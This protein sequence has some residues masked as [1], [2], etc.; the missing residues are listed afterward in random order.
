MPHLQPLGEGSWSMNESGQGAPTDLARRARS[1]MYRRR[2]IGVALAGAVVAGGVF[3]AVRSSTGRTAAVTTTTVITEAPTTTTTPPSTVV[4]TEPAST[5]TAVT[6]SAAPDAAAYR[7]ITRRDRDLE[8]TTIGRNGASTTKVVAKLLDVLGATPVL[9]GTKD[10]LLVTYLGQVTVYDPATWA[11][12]VDAGTYANFGLVVTG[13]GFWAATDN[14]ATWQLRDWSG[15]P[16]GSTVATKAQVTLPIGPAG[17]GVALLVK[18]TFEILI[19]EPGGVR[20]SG[21]G[22]PIAANGT[23]LAYQAES[24]DINIVNVQTAAVSVISKP[25]DIGPAQTLGS[26]AFSPDGSQLAVALSDNVEPYTGRGVL[27]APITGGTGQ[28]FPDLVGAGV[29]WRQD[30]TALVIADQGKAIRFDLAT[31]SS[32]PIDVQAQNGIVVLGR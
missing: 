14:G 21:V 24:G 31:A 18:E 32:Q 13:R 25:P 6:A 12:P 4:A 16:V 11:A 26:G 8:E 17:D 10:H 29:Q 28:I 7:L 23:H 5:S 3:T 19:A 2:R 1:R 27:V 15:Q 9:Y 20:V 30:G 22:R